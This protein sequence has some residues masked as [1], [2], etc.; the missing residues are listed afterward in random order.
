MH[1]RESGRGAS[2]RAGAHA[3]AMLVALLA[4]VPSHSNGATSSESA[5][6]PGET[7]WRPG[8]PLV[9]IALQPPEALDYDPQSLAALPGFVAIQVQNVGGRDVALPVLHASFEAR[10]EGVAFPCN[11]HAGAPPGELEPSH[12]APGTSF[13]FERRLDCRLPLTGRYDVRVWLHAAEAQEPTIAMVASG[14]AGSF[15]VDVRASGGNAPQSVPGHDRLYA[16]MTGPAVESPAGRDGGAAVAYMLVVALV[17]G[18]RSPIALRTARFSFVVL[19]SDGSPAP[20]PAATVRLEVPSVLSPGEIHIDRA[21][22]TCIPDKQ[23][24]YEVV[25]RFALDDEPELNIGRV[26]L[27]VT[28]YPN[29]LFTPAAPIHHPR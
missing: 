3:A 12:L 4:C 14:L 13:T 10:R 1:T 16:F 17:N 28:T 18:S 20:C 15:S 26:G 27:L 19:S 23:G 9:R 11:A 29:Y 21:A 22:V 25:G 7:T 24:Q 8:D 6:G 2:V 5:Q